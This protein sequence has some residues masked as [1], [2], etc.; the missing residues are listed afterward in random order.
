[1]TEWRIDDVVLHPNLAL[2]EIQRLRK[3]RDE[4]FLRWQ[5]LH[6]AGVRYACREGEESARAGIESS[7]THRREP[8]CPEPTGD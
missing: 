6:L 8:P 1:M 2:A 7:K 4:Y 5:N 3:E